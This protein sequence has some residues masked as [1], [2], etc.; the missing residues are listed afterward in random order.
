MTK[1]DMQNSP[2]DIYICWHFRLLS[3][4]V[5]QTI[6]TVA[7]SGEKAVTR[8]KSCK[9]KTSGLG[10]RDGS[11]VKS[12]ACLSKG[13]KFNSQQPQPQCSKDT[14]FFGFQAFVS[15]V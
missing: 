10:W 12:T 9:L 13:S 6:L 3:S 8:L 1:S 2:T 7:L 5:A 11:V 14:Q 4:N 15:L